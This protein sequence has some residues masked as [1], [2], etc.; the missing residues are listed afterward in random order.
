MAIN[1]AKI[2]QIGAEISVAGDIVRFSGSIDTPKPGLFL[3]PFFSELNTQLVSNG[4]N[5]VTID[6]RDLNFLNSSG[7]KEFVCWIMG[8]SELKES[9]Q[10]TVEFITNPNQVWQES[11]ITI[12]THLNKKLVKKTVA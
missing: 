10:Y 8:L 5:S 1:I 9:E 6:L 7:I 2:N 4:V 12:L 3:K 11:S